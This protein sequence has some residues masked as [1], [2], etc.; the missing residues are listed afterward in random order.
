MLESCSKLSDLSLKPH[1]LNSVM[2]QPLGSIPEAKP[3]RQE[4]KT[5][6]L[7]RGS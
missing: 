5:R 1:K 4:Q 7:G 6:I 3:L 2:T